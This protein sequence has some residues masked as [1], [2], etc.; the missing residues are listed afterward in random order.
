MTKVLLI[1][2]TGLIGRQLLG[3]LL[4][5][6]IES[7]VITRRPTGVEHPNLHELVAEGEDWSK[8]AGE[9]PADVAISCLGTTWAQAG[10]SQEAFRVVDQH[11]V[12]G[13]MKAAKE[14]GAH[15]AILVSA[16]G[17]RATSPNFYLRVKGEVERDLAALEFDRLDIMRPGLL[18][19]ERDAESRTGE[20]I[21]TLLSPITDVLMSV[22]PFR[23][24]RSIDSAQVAKAIF[25]LTGKSGKGRFI[26][27]NDAILRLG[28]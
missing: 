19:G 1:G 10:K 25:A 16:V 27:E 13:V 5:R 4:E 22:G 20:G 11:L 2:A 9:H 7:V 26:H 14:A 8:L 18:R 23:R 6:K 15:Q 24:F 28:N 21:A 12:L 17:A 3:R